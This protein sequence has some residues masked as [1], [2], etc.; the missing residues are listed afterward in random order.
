AQAPAQDVGGHDDVGQLVLD[1]FVPALPHGPVEAGDAA[2][3]LR[4][5]PLDTLEITGDIHF[6]AGFHGQPP[7]RKEM[8]GSFWKLAAP[9]P[10][11]RLPKGP[12]PAEA[13]QSAALRS[14]DRKP[15]PSLRPDSTPAPPPGAGIPAGSGNP[16]PS[17]A[18]Q[19]IL[20]GVDQLIGHL[21]DLL[22]RADGSGERV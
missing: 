9:R 18:G 11:N 17:K 15:Y 22:G 21:P 14:P 1:R 3:E 6:G 19:E 20:L 8:R 4:L 16:Q 2:Q 12:P 13:A 7:M 10:R 5:E